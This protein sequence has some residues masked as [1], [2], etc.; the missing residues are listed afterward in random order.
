MR[1]TVLIPLHRSAPWRASIA[2]QLHELTGA[3]H[4]IVS[5]ATGADE[6]LKELRDE[7]GHDPR[8][9]WLGTRPLA[10]GWVAHANDLLAQATTE[11]VMWLPHDD[12]INAHWVTDA[13]RLLDRHADAVAACGPIQAIQ[14]GSAGRGGAIA[15]PSFAND[16][17]TINRVGAAVDSLL[18]G[19]GGDLGIFFRSVVRKSL[20]PSLPT[21]LV[22][23]DW[24]DVLWALRLL[25]IGPV[26]PMTAVYKKRW[27]DAS[28]HAS[29]TDYTAEAGRLRRAIAQAMA[30]L[31]EPSHSEVLVGVWGRDSE[32]QW[33]ELQRQRIALEEEGQR[34][35]HAL[36]VLR[37]DFEQSTSWRATAPLRLISGLVR[38]VRRR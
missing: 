12:R 14:Y 37:G 19:R 21:G 2:E 6:T 15:I 26:A 34:V 24:A 3:A 18:T 36:A 4:V 11:F 20:A 28:T 1:T 32:R 9:T 27:H 29:W 35:D 33:A 10:P 25:C 30:G 38:S 7:C 22:G 23:D 31:P 8:I 13:E 5:D 17:E 16:S